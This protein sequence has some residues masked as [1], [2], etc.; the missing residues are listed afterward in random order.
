MSLL[1]N[2]SMYY[3]DWTAT[4]PMSN[5]AIEEYASC[6]RKYIGNPSSTHGLGMEA[7]QR[8]IEE[9]SKTAALLGTSPSNIYFTSG[10]TESDSIVLAS[11]LKSP[12]PGEIITTG[13]E[14]SAVL[15][16]KKTLEAAGWKFTVLSCPNGY[17]KLE[18]LEQAL[19]D[20]VKMVCVM[21]VN[22]VTGTIQD[23][24]A[25]AK[26]IRNKEKE[27]GR[28]IHFHCDAV[29]ALGKIP[30]NLAE[31]D[32]DSAA[33]SAHKFEGPRGVG[34]LYNRN[35]AITALSRGGGQE[36]GLRPGTENLP[37]ICA[38]NKA[39]EEALASLDEKYQ[40]ILV[41]RN[42]I[43]AIASEL[44]IKLLSPYSKEQVAFSPYIIS[45][46]V[47][48]VPS[49]VFLRVMSDKGFCLS[50]GSACSSNTK[51]KAE[52][53]LAAMN[54]DPMDR[55]SSIRISFGANTTEEE[56]MLLGKALKDTY[57]ELGYGK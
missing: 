41:F 3:F 16:W 10:G 48:P 25:I 42:K 23:T 24:K 1:Y 26:L 8:L 53:V 18:N 56:V 9:R 39:L 34:I 12:S 15:E 45:I 32:I 44:G 49:E 47:K 38:M 13:I 27:Y 55:R 43:E 11:L 28:H 20:K 57:K 51:G 31:E 37:G 22:N 33:F 7:A 21:K 46:S 30:F 50:A 4:T 54:K 19:N 5:S 40:Q 14:H 36:N 6:A 29:Q 52:G 2:F 35:K 17:L